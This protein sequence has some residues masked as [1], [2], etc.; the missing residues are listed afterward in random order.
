MGQG[1]TCCFQ[2]IPWGSR[3]VYHAQW[4]PRAS[5]GTM[6]QQREDHWAL[7]FWVSPPSS[8]PPQ[9]SSQLQTSGCYDRGVRR[10]MLIINYRLQNSLP[11]SLPAQTPTVLRL[12][13]SFLCF[14][15]VPPFS[16]LGLYC[17]PYTASTLSFTLSYIFKG[18][19]TK[20]SPKNKAI[21]THC[22]QLVPWGST[23]NGIL[24]SRNPIDGSLGNKAFHLTTL[25]K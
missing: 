13:P 8:N 25:T 3:L 11:P 23:E 21:W 4:E 17:T 19:R 24:C 16:F 6:T 15:S 9:A 14:A 22:R 12:L 7:K 18:T 2:K 10:W 1:D 20:S 5:A